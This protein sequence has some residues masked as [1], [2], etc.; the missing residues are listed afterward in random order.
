[1]QVAGDIWKGKTNRMGTKTTSGILRTVVLSVAASL[2]SPWAAFGNSVQPCQTTTLNNILGT[3]CAIG[4]VEFNFGSYFQGIS[5]NNQ[6][7][8]LTSDQILFTPQVSNSVM[9]FTLTP[10]GG[11]M[12]AATPIDTTLESTQL[13]D[14]YFN[15]NPLDG[16]TLYSMSASISGAEL[17]GFVTSNAE[18]RQYYPAD[19]QSTSKLALAWEATRP[20]GSQFVINPATV[21][22]SPY[23][24]QPSGPSSFAALYLQTCSGDFQGSCNPA[25]VSW[26]SATI[27]FN[28]PEPGSLILVGS[29]LI[30]L[31]RMFRRQR[32][33]G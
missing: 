9:E 30:G 21:S 28:T 22:L 23:G 14:F 20:D 27:S 4:S 17:A 33:N 25:S 10:E 5:S 15:V 31:A 1:M 32:I 2:F 24:G 11:A 13:T 12:F 16:T 29:G 8:S 26:S 3:V 18:S 7:G 6:W 19:S